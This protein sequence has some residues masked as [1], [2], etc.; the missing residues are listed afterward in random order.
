METNHD[1]AQRLIDK[2]KRGHDTQAELRVMNAA[3]TLAIADALRVPPEPI[4]ITRVD[5]DPCPE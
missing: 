3:A 2:Y 5:G 4:V 1:I